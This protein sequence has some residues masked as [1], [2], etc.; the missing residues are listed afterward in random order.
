MIFMIFYIL[1]KIKLRKN[2][3]IKFLSSH[4]GIFNQVKN[5]GF[6]VSIFS[7]KRKKI[8][9]KFFPDSRTLWG[10]VSQQ[11]QSRSSNSQIE[12]QKVYYSMYVRSKTLSETVPLQLQLQSFGSRASFSSNKSKFSCCRRKFLRSY[13]KL[14]FAEPVSYR[15][16][17][18]IHR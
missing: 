10:R 8:P 4:V 7:Q 14:T 17:V 12:A 9:R 13:N 15:L 6:L 3:I 16:K 2:T 11:Q 18:D 1:F 5:N